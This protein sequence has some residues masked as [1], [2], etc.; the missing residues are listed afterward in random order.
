MSDQHRATVT[1]GV[2]ALASLNLVNI[3]RTRAETIR[4]LA[5]ALKDA[6]AAQGIYLSISITL[7]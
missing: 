6:L 5:Q 4:N 1:G 2:G 7:S 3:D